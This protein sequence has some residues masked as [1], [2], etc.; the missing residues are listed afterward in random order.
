MELLEN[1][2]S[3]KIPVIL[4]F[5]SCSDI[6]CLK[7]LTIDGASVGLRVGDSVGGAVVHV[8]LAVSIR[9]SVGEVVGSFVGY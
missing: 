9:A 1:L 8:G 4:D 7:N 3:R 6:H 5:Q 2:H